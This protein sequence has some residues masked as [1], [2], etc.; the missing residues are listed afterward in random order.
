[1]QHLHDPSDM[2][3]AH[4]PI[5]ELEF[6]SY[7]SCVRFYESWARENNLAFVRGSW[8]RNVAGKRYKCEVRCCRAGKPKED[9]QGPRRRQTQSAKCGCPNAFWIVA[10]DYLDVDNSR[11]RILHMEG[12]KHA[13]RSLLHN[14]PPFQNVWVVPKYRREWRTE[15]VRA[16]IR[17]YFPTCNGAK[18]VLIQLRK[19]F[20]GL[21]L[22]RQDV[23]NEFI[24]AQREKLGVRT[25]VEVLREQLTEREYFHQ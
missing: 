15:D 3:R 18:E 25:K 6:D 17:S 1:M 5:P 10:L 11:W 2:L 4:P 14:H 9:K 13:R 12:Q 21:Q 8:R 23:R 16:K 7:E 24:A 20:P 22:T 19:D